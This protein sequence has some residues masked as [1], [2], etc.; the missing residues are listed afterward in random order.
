M[1]EQGPA[2]DPAALANGGGRFVN[3]AD[4]L[5]AYAKALAQLESLRAAFAGSAEQHW[6][7]IEAALT[8]AG[9]QIQQSA[10]GYS[11][12]GQ[13]MRTLADGVTSVDVNHGQGISST[14]Q[15]PR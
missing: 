9:G 14:G 15:D 1:G 7:A 13:T 3:H 5:D 12:V 6:P 8:G 2:F 11:G 4:G 10:Q